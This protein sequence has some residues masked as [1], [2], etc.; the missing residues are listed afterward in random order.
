MNTL[1][2]MILVLLLATASA[3]Q[4]SASDVVPIESV[5]TFVN[6]RFAPDAGSEVVGRL[7]QG[8]RLA[9]LRSVNGWHEVALEGGGTGYVSAEWSL[10]VDDEE[11]IVIADVNAVSTA[12]PDPDQKLSPEPQP[13]A[14]E[15]DVEAMPPEALSSIAEAEA[16]A[17][18]E[19]ATATETEAAEDAAVEAAAASKDK[20][21]IEAASGPATVDSQSADD[22]SEP[23][24]VV[25][26]PIVVASLP[27]AEVEVPPV[28]QSYAAPSAETNVEGSVDYLARFIAP[29]ELANSQIF[30]NGRNV[31]IGTNDP[32]Q[33]LEVNGNIQIYEQNSNVAGLII[34]QSSGDS[35]Y[36][37]H[38][39]ANTLTIGAGSVDRITITREGNAGFGVNRPSHP[40]EMSSGAHVTAGGVWT[41]S[42]SREKKENV[43]EL[44]PDEALAALAALQ[45]VLFNYTVDDT[46]QYVGFIAEDVPELVA[47]S[48][49]TGLSAMDIVAVLTS[50]VQQQQKRIDRL[51]ARLNDSSPGQQD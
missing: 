11:A 2:R 13:A 39:R 4:A 12:E 27:V 35:G 14:V 44:A 40:I 25:E 32:K 23:E 34:S 5:D 22:A 51:E 19:V 50:V 43:Q 37:M 42:S 29:T 28:V 47:T 7:L 17:E 9:Y 41:N 20:V 26:E 36:I 48:D 24:A 49:R 8:S 6:I 10:L 30:D 18:A 31:G 1:S 38:N 21:E 33:R 3:N 45:P 16:E 15:K 46:E